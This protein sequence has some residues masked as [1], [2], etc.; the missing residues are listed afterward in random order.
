MEAYRSEPTEL[1][2]G[3][4]VRFT[5]NDPASSLVNGQVAKVEAIEQDGARFRLE[6]GTAI[7]LSANDPQ[8]RHVDRAWASTVHAFQ[9]RTVDN[10]IA[11]MASNHPH[12]TTQKSLY[13]AISRARDSAELVTDDAARLSHHL[14]KA[15]GERIA[16]LD[17][18]KKYVTFAV[19]IDDVMERE[20][21][22]GRD[23]RAQ[24]AA[25]SRD[26]AREVSASRDL[27]R[28]LA[29]KVEHDVTREGEKRDADRQQRERQPADPVREGE[30]KSEPPRMPDRD[31]APQAEKESREKKIELDFELELE[32]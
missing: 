25:H 11:A 13:V 24:E 31:P 7:R 26:V 23:R 2:A 28:E 10:V 15:T 1:R 9:G 22:V 17:A 16:A 19:V 14:E 21:G 29:H 30:R 27:E 3:D 12:L 5:R 20:R 32:L 4:R 18:V 8:L 6:D